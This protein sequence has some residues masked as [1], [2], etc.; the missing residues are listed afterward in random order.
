MCKADEL[1]RGALDD[2]RQRIAAPRDKADRPQP[3][4]VDLR[5]P[6]VCLHVVVGDVFLRRLIAHAARQ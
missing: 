5:L 1:D 4:P 6:A 3:V 2:L